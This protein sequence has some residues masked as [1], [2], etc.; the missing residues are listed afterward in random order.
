MDAEQLNP[1]W[2]PRGARRQRLRYA[3]IAWVL[4]A[5][6]VPELAGKRFY[7]YKFP[8]VT[9]AGLA[10]EETAIITDQK[11]WLTQVLGTAT[12]A[13]AVTGSY[14]LQLFDNGVS[15]PGSFERFDSH[16]FQRRSIDQLRGS[17]VAAG[18][19]VMIKPHVIEPGRVVQ[20]RVTNLSANQNLVDISL[21]GYV[22]APLVGYKV[23]DG[24]VPSN[25]AT[26]RDLPPNLVVG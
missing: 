22:D 9:L 2:P 13:V 16:Y 7:H 1:K 14:R 17:V 23:D 3:P 20:L 24:G 26:N 10:T 4:G 8:R 25:A 11:F 5:P 6:A 18:A 21:F 15:V 12:I 19:P